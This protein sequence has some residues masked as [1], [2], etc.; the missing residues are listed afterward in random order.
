MKPVENSKHESPNA[1]N[2][3][4]LAHVRGGRPVGPGYPIGGPTGA[5]VPRFPRLPALVRPVLP[6]P[7]KLPPGT[8]PP[9]Y[10]IPTA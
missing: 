8:T 9:I 6:P 4:D 3:A 5:P 1:L 7:V 10:V 2:E